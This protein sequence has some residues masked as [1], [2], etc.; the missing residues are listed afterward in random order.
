MVK[1][2]EAKIISTDAGTTA[3]QG[4]LSVTPAEGQALKA[5]KLSYK[6]IT[7]AEGALPQAY[8]N[9]AVYCMTKKTFMIYIGMTDAEGQPVA[10]I[11]YGIGGKPERSLLGRT[12]VLCGDYLDSFSATLETGKIFAFLFNFADYAVNTVYDMGVQRK[13]DWD[14]EDLLTKAVM[15]LDGKVIDINSLVTIEKRSVKEV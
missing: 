13:Q 12:V 6:L 9:G 8:E 14:T 11:N 3:M 15:S 2:I 5:K 7:D 1:A 4:I 10:R